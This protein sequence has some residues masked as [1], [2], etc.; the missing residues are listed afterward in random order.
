MDD[1]IKL[2]IA[3]VGEERIKLDEQLSYHTFSKLGGAAQYFYIAT[4]QRELI[5]IMDLSW[6]LKIPYIILG[7]GTKL[8]VSEKGFSGLVIKNRTSA[9]KIGGI[10]GKV[11]KAGIGIEEALVEVDSGV[12]LNKLNEFLKEQKLK[13]IDSFSSLKSSVGGAI[14]LDKELQELAQQ[15]NVW[16]KG[17]V[18][19]ILTEE[20]NIRDQVVL[21]AV[22]KVKAEVES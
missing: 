3:E 20:L 1:K 8:L 7:N 5:K 14:F 6:E 21:S 13:Q 15:V 11:G 17:A 2:I 12:S 4:T 16:D 22:V 18:S 19:V 9:I 10:K